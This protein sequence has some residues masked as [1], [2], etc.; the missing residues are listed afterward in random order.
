MVVEINNDKENIIF[1]HD[2]GVNNCYV[3]ARLM[4]FPTI[5]SSSKRTIEN[6][7]YRIFLR[8]F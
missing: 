1:G 6:Y 7:C 4:L 8:I 2:F 5:E 3:M